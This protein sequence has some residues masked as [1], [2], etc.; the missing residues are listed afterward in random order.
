MEQAKKEVEV[1]CH[2][3]IFLAG[4]KCS[5]S[6]LDGKLGDGGSLQHGVK[7]RFSIPHLEVILNSQ[8]HTQKLQDWTEH[9]RS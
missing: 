9:V 8:S 6:R 1:L 2:C 5:V 7:P 4:T 3:P